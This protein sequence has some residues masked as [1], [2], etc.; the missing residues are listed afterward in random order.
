MKTVVA[1]GVCKSCFANAKNL[2]NQE[3]LRS[4]SSLSAELPT[5]FLIHL[6]SY[7]GR[8]SLPKLYSLTFKLCHSVPPPQGPA[9]SASWHQPNMSKHLPKPATAPTCIDQALLMELVNKCGTPLFVKNR[10][11]RFVL[12]NDAMCELVGLT[13]QDMLGKNDFDLYS[14]LLYTSPSP[15]DS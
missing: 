8:V 4:D 14:C 13:P 10:E 5:G 12:V 11:H 6:V 2:A 15:R 9:F 3:S 7:L 1:D